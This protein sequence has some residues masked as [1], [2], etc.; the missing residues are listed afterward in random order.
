M[1]TQEDYWM[2]QELHHQGVYQGFPSRG[3]NAVQMRSFRPV[4]F[5]RMG[6]G[7]RGVASPE[8]GRP[9]GKTGRFLTGRK[10]AEG[11]FIRNLEKQRLWREIVMVSEG[12]QSTSHIRRFITN[13]ISIS[14]A[15]LN[16]IAVAAAFYFPMTSETSRD[17]I[18]FVHPGKTVVVRTGQSSKI[19]VQL[20]G[21]TIT[22]DL[23]ASRIAVWNNGKEPIHE[24]NLLGSRR[25]LITTGPD[26]PIID[27]KI[28]KVSRDEIVKLELDH[29]ENGLGQLKA[30]W[31]ILEH[32]DWAIL[33][34]IYFGDAQT[35]II[36][37][38]T[39]EQQGD[40][41]EM[42]YGDTIRTP[43]DQYKSRV[44]KQKVRKLFGGVVIMVGLATVFLV[45]RESVHRREMR[46]YEI[47]TRFR[48]LRSLAWWVIRAA[49]I[50]VYVGSG[51]YLLFW[52]GLEL[53]PPFDF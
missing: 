35:P 41:R 33:Q 15:L 8:R 5:F 28:L 40:I 6:R 37:S 50:L 13:P 3:T 44:K 16:A 36:V 27:A 42:E 31:E 45:Y 18:Y 23:T 32:R 22:E 39:V 52:S 20:E 29:S 2:I 10:S 25:L 1:L 34:L 46:R 24:H 49:L 11:S 53:I 26:N 43:D 9:A 51:G 21:E 7:G 14:S 30:K 38:A 17:L 47:Q 19:S 48:S 4:H 12:S